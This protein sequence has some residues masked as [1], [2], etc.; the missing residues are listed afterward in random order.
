MDFGAIHLK[1]PEA[2][3]PGVAVL[4]CNTN[5]DISLRRTLENCI[6]STSLKT[7]IYQ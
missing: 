5:N 4:N 6:N 2:G 1:M 3:F 7:L